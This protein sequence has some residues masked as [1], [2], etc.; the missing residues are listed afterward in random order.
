MSPLL[1]IFC[2]GFLKLIDTINLKD[3]S[4]FLLI[5]SNIFITIVNFQFN[6]IILHNKLTTKTVRHNSD[7]KRIKKPPV[8]TGVKFERI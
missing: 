1:I 4:Y 8:L 6:Y 7:I 2:K 5:I 3:T